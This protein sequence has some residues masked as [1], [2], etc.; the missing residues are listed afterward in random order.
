MRIVFLTWR[1]V[2]AEELKKCLDDSVIRLNLEGQV[3]HAVCVHY[4]H[5]FSWSCVLRYY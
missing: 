5:L 1:F 2:V 3:I 4:M